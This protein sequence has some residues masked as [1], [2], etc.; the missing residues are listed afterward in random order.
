MFDWEDCGGMLLRE[1]MEALGLVEKL[2]GIGKTSFSVS[3]CD[4]IIPH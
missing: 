3:H 1:E 4:F 2:G